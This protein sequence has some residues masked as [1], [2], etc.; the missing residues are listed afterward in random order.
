MQSLLPSCSASLSSEGTS[1]L[2]SLH[3]SS[4]E[5]SETSDYQRSTPSPRDQDDDLFMV[6][7]NKNKTFRV[8]SPDLS[9]HRRKNKDLGFCKKKIPT[10]YVCVN[11]EKGRN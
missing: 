6:A 8:S 9:F 7:K 10:I 4:E 3:G 2:G 5:L 11:R 1:G